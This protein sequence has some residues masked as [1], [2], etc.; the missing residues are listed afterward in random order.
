M[1]YQTCICLQ[2]QPDF[3]FFWVT[4]GVRGALLVEMRFTSKQPNVFD[5]TLERRYLFEDPPAFFNEQDVDT[6]LFAVTQAIELFTGKYP[7][8]SVRCKAGD[9][10][11]NA[12]FRIILRLNQ[13]ALATLFSVEEEQKDQYRSFG[14]RP[15]DI[16]SF[17]LKRKPDALRRPQQMQL[18]L[19]TYSQLFGN[20]VFVRLCEQKT[21]ARPA[22]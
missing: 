9:K 13:D 7:E 15:P 5:L 1:S 3:S 2:A 20:P 16:P 6:L 11:Q 21:P 10:V 8:R 22:P 14:R 12:I 19:N 4:L 18:T 17:L